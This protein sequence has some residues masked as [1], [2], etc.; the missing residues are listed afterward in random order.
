[1]SVSVRMRAFL[2]VAL[3][4][5]SAFADMHL[6]RSA[7]VPERI[8]Q[9][10]AD[11]QLT[12]EN[13]SADFSTPRLGA[14]GLPERS[15]DALLATRY[16]SLA[17]T[18]GEV[19]AKWSELQNR[20]RADEMAIAAC[21]SDQT[22]CTQAARQFLAIVDLGRKREG[23]IR[24]GWINRAVNLAIR[25]TS[26]WTQ[27]GYADFWAS[28]LQTLGRGAGDCEDYAIVKYIALRELGISP[29]DLKLV[30][31]QDDRFD[32]SHA[33]VAVRSEQHW[34]ILDNRTMAILDAEDAHHY[35]PLFALDQQ[36]VHIIS[37]AAIDQITDR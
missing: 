18:A 19:F 32:L 7:S 34:L 10:R 22:A 24:L 28:P 16:N 13:E 36:R 26:D 14:S 25:P 37:T 33:I 23:R 8:E 35:R 21:L 29:H 15:K 30:I 5:G 2:L 3:C 31:V 1:M 4:F 17:M 12:S 20:I 9:N 6:G 27:Y 11:V